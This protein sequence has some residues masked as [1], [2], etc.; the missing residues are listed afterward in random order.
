MAAND[1]L[2]TEQVSAFHENGYLIIRNALLPETVSSL[3]TETHHLLEDM[4]LTNHPLTRFSTG[5]KSEH[6]GDDYFLTSGDK[7][8]FFFEEEAFNEAGELIKPKEKAVN[9]IG[10]YLHEL[11]PPFKNLLDG[12][13]ARDRGEVSPVAIARSLGYSDPRVLQ[14]MVIC[15][16]PEI[17]GEVPPHQDSTVRLKPS[18]NGSSTGPASCPKENAS[19]E[20]SKYSY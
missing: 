19:E 17:G 15:K 9:K 14:S 18:L 3:L 4:D 6:V 10:H 5:Q 20:A 7:V 16:Q 1:G 8:R 2:S 12:D 13:A 11:S